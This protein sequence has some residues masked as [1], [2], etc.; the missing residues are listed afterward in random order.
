M[1]LN[2]ARSHGKGNVVCDL[3]I[4]TATADLADLLKKTK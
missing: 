3:D 1:Q 2:S 4:K